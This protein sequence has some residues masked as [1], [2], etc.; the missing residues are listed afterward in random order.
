MQWQAGIEL[1]GTD[2]DPK[3]LAVLQTNIGNETRPGNFALN[4]GSVWDLDIASNTL[5]GGADWVAVNNGSAALN[6]GVLNIHQIGGYTPVVGD[7]VTIVR[8]L[9]NGITLTSLSVSDPHWQ[10]YLASSNT[11]LRLKYT[12]IAAI[13]GD[14]DSNGVVDAKDYVLWRKSPAAYGGNPAGYNT[15]R[16]NFGRP[17]GS[18]SS[19]GGSAVPE[20]TSIV[21]VGLFA[22]ALLA[23][24]RGSR[25]VEC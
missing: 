15:W 8:D 7:E 24:R 20:P 19:L 21:L 2:F 5:F 9:I 4:T 18:G 12:A 6:G 22:P 1:Q 10:P 17:P 16:T 23:R 13:P 3:P 14:Y 11:E 25:R